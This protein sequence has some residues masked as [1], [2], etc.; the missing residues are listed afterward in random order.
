MYSSLWEYTCRAAVL[1]KRMRSKPVPKPLNFYLQVGEAPVLEL[2]SGVGLVGI[3]LA[4]LGHKVYQ[5]L[6][7]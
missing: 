4:L 3:A 6:T 2:G 5:P 7:Y 1:S